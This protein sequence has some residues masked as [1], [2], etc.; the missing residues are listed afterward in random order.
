MTAKKPWRYTQREGE[1]ISLVIL[2]LSMPEMDGKKCLEEILRVNTKAK[3]IMA[4]GY[5]E[6]GLGSGATAVAMGFIQKPYDIRQ[7]LTA[8]RAILDSD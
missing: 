3:V 7:L 6:A 4:S 5:S 1:R 2:Y 8:I